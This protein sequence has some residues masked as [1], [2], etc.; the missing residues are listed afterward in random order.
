[1]KK[2]CDYCK[3]S[4]HDDARGNCCACGAPRREQSYRENLANA[5][6]WEVI[7]DGISCAMEQ[8]LSMRYGMIEVTA[9]GDAERS[10]IVG[11]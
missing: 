6:K 3:G 5:C 10:F 9:L 8:G 1:M 7:S 2:G 11:V 4:T